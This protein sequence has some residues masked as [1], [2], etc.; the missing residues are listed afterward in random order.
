ML[1]WQDL[2]DENACVV[3]ADT[4]ILPR[5]HIILINWTFIA[6]RVISWG[7]IWLVL[8]VV[9]RTMVYYEIGSPIRHLCSSKRT[10][11]HIASN[12]PLRIWRTILWKLPSCNLMHKVRRPFGIEPL[13]L[14]RLQTVCC[15]LINSYS[16]LAISHFQFMIPGMGEKLNILILI[17]IYHTAL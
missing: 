8:L 6:T 11:Y 12:L 17:I 2:H 16:S 4:R 5:H 1:G 13:V 9:G 3:H 7:Q 15:E 10:Y 14:T